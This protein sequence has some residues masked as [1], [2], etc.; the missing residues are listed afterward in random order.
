MAP[1]FNR[2]QFGFVNG[3]DSDSL[4]LTCGIPQESVVEHLLFLLYVNGLPNTLKC[5]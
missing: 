1:V 5:T 2:E 3:H 4:L